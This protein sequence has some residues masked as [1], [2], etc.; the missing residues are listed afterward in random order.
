[1][2]DPSHAGAI[3]LQQLATPGFSIRSQAEAVEGQTHQ[4]WC[5]V[6]TGVF[7]P[8]G[9]KVG[10]VVLNGLTRDAARGSQRLRVVG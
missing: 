9:R 4:M 2:P 8:H 1:M 7:G 10:M 3:Q 5:P 6:V